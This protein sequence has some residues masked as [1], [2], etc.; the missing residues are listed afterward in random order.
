[1]SGRP[2]VPPGECPWA[3][4]AARGIISRAKASQIRNGSAR[5]SGALVRSWRALGYDVRIVNGKVRCEAWPEME[6]E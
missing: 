5:P 2:P 6:R 3:A 1:M 4:L